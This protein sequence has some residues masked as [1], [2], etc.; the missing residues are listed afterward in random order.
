V[1]KPKGRSSLETIGATGSTSRPEWPR[2]LPRRND[3]AAPLPRYYS[4]FNA[5]RPAQ[6]SDYEKL[7]VPWG[8]HDNYVVHKKLGRGK[9]SEVFQGTHLPTQKLCV[10]K[11]LKPVRVKKIQREIFILQ[12]LYGGTN[13]IHLHDVVRDP[14]TQCPALVFEHVKNTDFRELYPTF[15]DFDVR[16]YLFEILR[17]LDFC[18]AQG[19]MHRDVKPQNVMIDH[20]QR[21]L[22]LIDW[23]LAE[24]YHP[25]QEYNVRVAS[26][27]Y[28][29]PELL[30]DLQQY[31]YSLDIWSLGCVMAG[32][33][34][35]TEPFFMGSDNY[36]QLAKIAR[37]LGTPKLLE[38]VGR[39]FHQ[40]PP[41][42]LS[43]V[44]N[45]S[46]KFWTSFITPENAEYC[47]D[48]HVFDLLGNMLRYD[49]SE[50]ILPKEAMRHPYF[51]MIR[52]WHTA[53]VAS[54]RGRQDER[55]GHW[56]AEDILYTQAVEE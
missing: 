49:H 7:K 28:K 29:G 56:G 47:G 38:W 3:Y 2:G 18:H 45:H 36:D 11:M 24:L 13:I 1:R 34:F 31:D 15:S 14:V 9:Y 39:Y 37:V 55:I 48:D 41:E 54:E 52:S 23:G 26:R 10:I 35:Q 22:R 6:Y 5:E 30:V 53:D 40:S 20:A 19:V 4:H 21:K 33:I 44:G 32:M 50:R 25:G 42:F 8:V 27:Y 12:R 46:P 51:A 16:F 17:A 43:I